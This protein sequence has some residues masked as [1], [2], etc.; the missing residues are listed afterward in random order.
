V[1]EQ[2]DLGFRV[3]LLGL[4]NFLTTDTH[5]TGVVP[6][7]CRLRTL[8]VC[9]KASWTH[10]WDLA[11]D[12]I[13]ANFAP[14]SDI[15]L[16]SNF[17]LTIHIFYVFRDRKDMKVFPSLCSKVKAVADKFVVAGMKFWVEF[18]LKQIFPLPGISDELALAGHLR[19]SVA[20]TGL[21]E[22]QSTTQR[23]KFQR[24]YEPMAE[25]MLLRG[26]SKGWDSYL[27]GPSRPYIFKH[28]RA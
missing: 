3:S 6:A 14:L 10:P 28:W 8:T 11:R 9:V 22:I 4:Q 27:T 17:K 13:E 21:P 1:Y 25:E 16:K 20:V 26:E 7:D 19:P 23:P 2:G 5:G 24:I 18:M 15:K 12:V